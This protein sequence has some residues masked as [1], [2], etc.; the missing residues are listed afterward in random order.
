VQKTGQYNCPN[1]GSEHNDTAKACRKGHRQSFQSLGQPS[2]ASFDDR[3]VCLSDGAAEGA[4]HGV[5][6]ARKNWTF[7]GSD[8]GGR[9]VAAVSNLSC[10]INDVDP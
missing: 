1:V 9:R 5:A 7:A 2:H 6:V 8:A 10:K 3:R 4:L